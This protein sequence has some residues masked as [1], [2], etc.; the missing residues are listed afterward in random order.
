[1]RFRSVNLQNFRNLA[2]AS[3]TFAGRRTFLVGANGQGKSNF[4]E[5]LGYVTALRSFRGAEP[6]ALVG[7]GADTAGAGFVLEHET[8]GE[9]RITVTLGPD[10]RE[11]AWEQG[12]VTRLGDF[13][14]RFPTVAFSAQD[15]QLLRGA[16]ALRRRWLDLTLAA[17]NPTYLSELQSYTRAVA[18]RNIL[19]K[20]GG[21]DAA[22]LTAFEHEAAAHAA[23][24]AAQRAAGVAELGGH[25]GR[26]YASLVP[27]GETAGLAY[28]P[29][30]P[31]ESAAEFA[32]RL[33]RNRPRDLALK[34]TTQG[35]H[36]DDL[37]LTLGDRPA[38]LFASE[39]Q[40]RCAVLA[41]KLAQAAYFTGHAHVLPVLLCDD[42]LGELDAGR[43]ERFWA[44]LDVGSQVIATGT[45]RPAGAAAWQCL[46][47][48][49]GRIIEATD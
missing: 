3:V 9:S 2:L 32:V 13:I 47:V 40:Q 46:E 26:S 1:M 28:T 36:R 20:H 37:E 8:L 16:P 49:A 34:S 35:P 15:H 23:P 5:A 22:A 19:L 7:F 31:A 10:G 29:D 27:E 12:R 25:F 45:A 11:V 48:A 38:R 4:L 17:M 33:Q 44:S 39:G 18:E 41:L 14:G 30:V 24:L 6:R 21:R 43:R 42:V